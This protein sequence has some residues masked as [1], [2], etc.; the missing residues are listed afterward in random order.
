[1]TYV[2][3]LTQCEALDGYGLDVQERLFLDYV[4]R[5]GLEVV[6]VHK[7]EGLSGTLLSA[8]RPALMDGLSALRDDLAD[9]LVVASLDRLARALTTQEAIL[10][11]CWKYGAQVHAADTGRVPED[12]PDGLMRTA[13]RQ[14]A[15]VFA[16]LDRAVT[17]KR[18]RD[19]RK[20]KASKGGHPSG[21]YLYGFS[22]QRPVP[23]E[24]RVLA[25]AKAMRRAGHDWQASADDL[26]QRGL[27]PR[28][29]QAWTKANIAKVIR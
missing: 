24:Q 29:A 16:E 9:V 19:G 3:V 12:D 28:K 22:K 11:E 15:G 4:K 8:E 20:A 2:R 21:S 7:D 6:D 10:A 14:M 27:S 26:T 17:V 23:G 25:E 13:M 5:A 1:M 18:P